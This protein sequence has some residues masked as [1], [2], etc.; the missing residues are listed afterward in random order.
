MNHRTARR[1]SSWGVFLAALTAY[2][3]TLEPE[4][5]FWDCPEYLVSAIRLEPGHPPGNPVWMLTAKMFALLGDLIYHLCSLFGTSILQ[6]TFE[7]VA[8]N[9]SSAL[10]TAGACAMLAS[11]A[12]ILLKLWRPRTP[13]ATLTLCS[14]CAALTFAW[15]D[16]PWFSAVE[17]E[18][19]AM[20]LFLTALCFRMMLGWAVTPK[21]SSRPRIL[22][23]IA[24]ILGLSIGVHQLNL[25]VIPALALI[26]YFKR[27][28]AKSGSP[29]KRAVK[30]T[31]VLLLSLLAVG[32]ILLLIMP[33]TIILAGYYELLLT[34]NIKA[35]PMHSGVWIFWLCILALLFGC[36]L[37]ARKK[38]SRIPHSLLLGAWA[39]PLLL[40]GYSA[41]ML[42]LVRGAANPPMNEGSPSDI[43]RLREY[44]A[45]E[46]Y[47]S[48]P[49]LYGRTPYSEIMRLEKWNP[50]STPN[51]N[52]YATKPGRLYYAPVLPG[53]ELPQAFAISDSALKA[54]APK[55]VAYKRKTEYVYTPELDMWLPRITSSDPADIS[56]YGDWS[57]FRGSAMDSV[58]I[59]YALDTLGHP[60]QK[61]LAD[62]SREARTAKRPTYL[63]NVRYL[64]SYQVYYMYLRYLLWNFAGRQNDRF[65]C[66]E[67]EHGN[68]ITGIPLVDNAMLGNQAMLP[69]E[70]GADN[71]GR[72]IY[73]MIPLLIA[74]AGILYLQKSRNDRLFSGPRINSIIL[75]LFILTG[76]A[77]VV[78]L[79]QTP[80]E[81]RERDYSFLGSFWAFSLWI[82][83]GFAWLLSDHSNKKKRGRRAL[84]KK[85]GRRWLRIAGTAV[86][87]AVP[88][89][90]L[91]VNYGDHDR[92]GRSG[93]LHLA[94]NILETLE[95]DAIL[96]TTGDNYTFPLWYAQEVHGV[97]RDV[98]VVSTAYLSTP[99]YV[100][101]L[102]RPGEEALPVA[103][104]GKYTQY[105]YDAR[106]FTPYT[107]SD[108][109]TPEEEKRRRAVDAAQALDSIFS[110]PPGK[111]RVPAWLRLPSPYTSNPAESPAAGNANG[112]ESC[113]DSIYF[114][115]G[116]VACASSQMRIRNLAVLD[117]VATNAYSPAPRPIYWLNLLPTSD[118]TAFLPFTTEGLY[119]RKLTYSLTTDSSLIT[120]P[121]SLV[122]LPGKTRTG[123]I[124]ADDS[125]G[126]QITFQRVALIR[127][128][129]RL[130]RNG[131]PQQA[132][133]VARKTEALFPY[134][135]W[136]YQQLGMRDSIVHEG[137]DLARLQMESL[138]RLGYGRNSKEYRRAYALLQRESD[139][140]AQW[141][142]YRNALPRR[143]HHAITPKDTRKANY[144]HTLDSLLRQYK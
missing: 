70:V 107:A 140:Y 36:A 76:L 39:L 115:A 27:T 5:A 77:I 99:W 96:F 28:P 74:I 55:Y 113:R 137:I 21:R 106:A 131:H 100:A 141:S 43:F 82:A 48:T 122:T 111:W 83:A 67:A 10:F 11:S 120:H 105:L 143:M 2:L 136:E 35:L 38:A 47:G 66:G 138:L 116:A 22:L 87:V 79:N 58:Q 57:G 110:N 1:A 31:L 101:Q 32:V 132:L 18:V 63:Q 16:S 33:G 61:L 133:A 130:L 95:P 98:T 52:S 121:S 103:M 81:P 94:T 129:N 118:Y 23:C 3:L 85:R 62:G 90:M 109:L 40:T 114:S 6:A 134:T 9:A 50:D 144:T 86:C 112:S 108:Y 78:Y 34:S 117:L 37:L 123:A 15:S 91:A 42:L 44:L 41:Y 29:R 102:Q 60:V 53:M 56:A 89:W 126:P 104:T 19:Y 8:V 68:F 65:A 17:A 54:D 69:D 125:F 13:V 92:S 119:T 88:L 142:R 51:Y 59:S 4:A 45:R 128:G 25:L 49:L 7:V 73:F 12:F 75:A 80:R 20:S 124:Y 14:V 30:L 46:Q 72:N 97:R 135:D 93:P 84:K 71:R 64:L 139:R 26:W 127:L 24:Y